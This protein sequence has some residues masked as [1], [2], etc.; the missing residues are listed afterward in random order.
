MP[1]QRHWRKTSGDTSMARQFLA[2]P[3]GAPE[4]A[5]RWA[6]R[7]P[8]LAGALGA[9]AFLLIAI[10]TIS[11]I[12]AR[13]LELERDAVLENLRRAQIAEADSQDK[14]FDSLTAQRKH[15]GSAAASVKDSNRSRRSSLRRRS[16]ARLVTQKNDWIGSATKRS[17]AWR[18]PT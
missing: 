4:R 11:T 17:P 1:R 7:M 2:R 15:A 16:G 10:A 9:M 18:C 5:W 14:L 8:A 13:R 3:V 6:R 12:S